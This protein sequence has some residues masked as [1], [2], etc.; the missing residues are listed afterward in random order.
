MDHLNKKNVTK[1]FHATIIR[2]SFTIDF[3]QIKRK[4]RK[5]ILYHKYSCTK[6]LHLN[7]SNYF[8]VYFPTGTN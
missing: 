6:I 8:V 5:N 7:K 1:K 3:H 4:R 2:Q